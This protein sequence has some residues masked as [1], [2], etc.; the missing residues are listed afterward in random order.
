MD[1]EVES[2]DGDN[3]LVPFRDAIQAQGTRRRRTAVRFAH[4]WV[5]A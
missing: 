3:G 5:A 1:I 2:I 4:W